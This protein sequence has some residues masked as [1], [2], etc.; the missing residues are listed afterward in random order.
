MSIAICQKASSTCTSK[1]GNQ[2]SLTGVNELTQQMAGQRTLK[3]W[4]MA[5]LALS[6]LSCRA[7]TCLSRNDLL[8]YVTP[9]AAILRVQGAHT[10]PSRDPG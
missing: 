4:K 10:G 2:L 9:A 8:L 1:M 5:A 7:H 6:K 3:I